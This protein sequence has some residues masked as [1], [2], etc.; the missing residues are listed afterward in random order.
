MPSFPVVPTILLAEDDPN[1]ML[2]L[3]ANLAE[4]G[5]TH[6]MQ[7]FGNG[8][9]VIQFLRE[10]AAAVEG[11]AHLPHCVLFLDLHLPQVDGC[12]VL[13]WA[14]RQKALGNLRIIIL[15]GSGDSKDMQRAAALRPDRMLVK[16]ATGPALATELEYLARWSSQMGATTG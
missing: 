7:H 6:P 13:A 15:S 4:M 16:P 12:G 1:D 11:G 14:R 5:S 3:Q 8:A 9:E 10:I 2:L